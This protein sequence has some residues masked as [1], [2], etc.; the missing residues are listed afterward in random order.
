MSSQFPA[1]HLHGKDSHATV[2]TKCF[3]IVFSECD[4]RRE[5][6]LQKEINVNE[7]R[8][9]SRMSPDTLS[10]RWGLRM[11]LGVIL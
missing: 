11:R 8:G 10:H 6:S 3:A 7:A 4:W 5:I 1:L 9:I 2:V